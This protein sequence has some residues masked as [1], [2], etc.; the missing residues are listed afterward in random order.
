MTILYN[1]TVLR[2]RR[3]ELRRN[4]TECEK[5][6]W[7]RL[8]RR[9]ML[10]VKFRRQY[11][12]DAYVIDFYCPKLKLAVEVDGPSHGSKD[13]EEYDMVRQ[14]IIERCGITFLRFNNADVLN[15]L[16]DVLNTVRAIIHQRGTS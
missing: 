5:I 14:E 16:G 8:K 4:A 9:Q 2:D 10:G 15:N 13:A 7:A 12:V 6:L 11:S 3:K 1:K